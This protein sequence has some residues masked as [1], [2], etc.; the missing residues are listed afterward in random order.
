MRPPKSRRRLR[1]SKRLPPRQKPSKRTETRQEARIKKRKGQ[2][3]RRRAARH[4]K[5]RARQ[6][7]VQVESK[8]FKQAMQGKLEKQGKKAARKRQEEQTAPIRRPGSRC[9]SASRGSAPRDL[10][11]ADRAPQC[12]LKKELGCAISRSLRSFSLSDCLGRRG[13][14]AGT[15][16]CSSSGARDH[17]FYLPSA[18]VVIYLNRLMPLEG[19]L[20]N[21]RN[22]DSAKPRA[23]MVPGISG[24]TS[25]QIR[26]RSGCN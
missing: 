23:F 26:R 19:G 17:V 5:R 11:S 14:K 9:P 15:G 24:S 10:L 25:S 6:I 3:H 2:A 8:S 21:G 22:S 7:R 12:R 4:L 18:A 13:R 20:Y 1:N 16:A